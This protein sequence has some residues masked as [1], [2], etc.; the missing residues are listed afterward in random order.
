MA[1]HSSMRARTYTILEMR[2]SLG[3]G[4]RLADV[5]RAFLCTAVACGSSPT[6]P[7][8]EN[9]AGPPCLVSPFA[10]GGSAINDWNDSCLGESTHLQVQAG[11]NRGTVI[12]G[13]SSAGISVGEE[14]TICNSDGRVDD[15]VIAWSI[16]DQSSGSSNRIWID[17]DDVAS[18]SDRLYQD[19]GECLTFQYAQPS[20][21][22]PTLRRWLVHGARTRQARLKVQNLELFP[23]LVSAAITGNNNDWAP[24]ES[25]DG[26]NYPEAGGTGS[27]VDYTMI[28]ASTVDTT[29]ATVTGLATAGAGNTNTGKGEG[30]FRCLCNGGPGVITVTSRDPSSQAYNQFL[31][32]DD[33]PITIQAFSTRCFWSSGAGW[34]SWDQ[35]ISANNLVG[36]SIPKG[37]SAGGTNTLTNSAI[38]DVGGETTV[39]ALSAL[40]SSNPGGISG[41]QVLVQPTGAG[42]TA[43]SFPGYDFAVEDTRSFDTTSSSIAY[44]GGVFE[45]NASRAAGANELTAVALYATANNAQDNEAIVTGCGNIYFG[46]GCEMQQME[47]NA[48]KLDSSGE[49]IAEAALVV[50]GGDFTGTARRQT[51]ASSSVPTTSSGSL[52]SDSSNFQGRVSSPTATSVTLT[53]GGGAIGSTSHCYY[54]VE[55]STIQPIGMTVNPGAT[56]VQFLCYLTTTGNATTCPTFSYQC[57]GH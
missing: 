20:Q 22:D 51:A 1:D 19:T 35:G 43:S 27:A 46:Q 45:L 30:A 34:L 14:R 4:C 41:A 21:D 50:G 16:E 36:G 24:V 9:E 5:V 40:D 10:T 56:S 6:T 3:A 39:G 29:G 17:Y 57:W 33:L 12:T 25:R 47:V 7:V 53:Y 15:G 8:S 37:D 44:Y 52:S 2:Y 49:V 28:L 11:D 31:L 18:F 26:S 23:W 32:P 48:S 13:I 42:L 38:T 55:S 54:A